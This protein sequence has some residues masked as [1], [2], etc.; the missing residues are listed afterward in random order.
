MDELKDIMTEAL[1]KAY[2]T[3]YTHGRNAAIKEMTREINSVI[4]S[5]MEKEDNDG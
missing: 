3:G 2:A 5:L 4:H 1:E